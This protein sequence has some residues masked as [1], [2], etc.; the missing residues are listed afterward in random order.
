MILI[1]IMVPSGNASEFYFYIAPSIIISYDA[2]IQG[3]LF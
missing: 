1:S 2:T 3:S